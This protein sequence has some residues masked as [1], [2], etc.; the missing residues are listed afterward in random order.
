M[1]TNYIRLVSRTKRSWRSQYKFLLLFYFNVFVAS[2]SFSIVMPSIWLYIKEQNGTDNFLGLVLS[3]YSLGEVLGAIMFGNL[4]DCCSTKTTL[5][6][7]MGT[8]L[9]GSVLYFLA[10]RFQSGLWMVLAGRVLQGVWTGGE[11]AVEQ[12]YIT[13]VV[14]DISKFKALG[15]VGMANMLGYILGPI[16]GVLV[17]LINIPTVNY[18]TSP[19]Y[20]QAFLAITLMVVN[21]VWFKEIKRSERPNISEPQYREETKPNPKGSLFCM[22]A[23]FVIFNGFTVQETITTPLVTDVGKYTHS[24]GWSLA[25]VYCLFAGAGIVS[26]G[27]LMFTRFLD[28]RLGD[29]KVLSVALCIGIVG[30]ALFIDF[31]YKRIQIPAFIVGFAL[32]SSHFAIGRNAL[33]SIFSKIIGPNPAGKY[34]GFMTAA[35]SLART[36]SPFW[37]IQSL[38][39]SVKV[40]AISCASLVL[41]AFVLLLCV[42]KHCR[43]HPESTKADSFFMKYRHRSKRHTDSYKES[44]RNNLRNLTI[45]N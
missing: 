25:E 37:A 30:W 13:E 44:K 34:M 43:P 15:E 18:Y 22:L 3:L 20:F 5:I 8:G 4:H 24:F 23:C 19:G 10:E 29:R 17:S 2:V 39:I 14:S 27:S 9:L 6:L 26:I 1:H 36:L 12:A 40:S 32:I 35:G 7:A 42:W 16:F 38:N 28:D 33:F 41:S 21:F 11:Q 31:S 45:S